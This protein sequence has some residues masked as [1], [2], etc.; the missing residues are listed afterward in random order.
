MVLFVCTQYSHVL[1]TAMLFG[2]DFGS[3]LGGG[4]VST[5]LAMIL[6]RFRRLVLVLYLCN[7]GTL[8][9]LPLYGCVSC[10]LTSM[11]GMTWGSV[12]DGFL[13]TRPGVIVIFDFL[14]TL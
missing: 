11:S 13:F 1:C 10:G 8:Y 6:R 4:I 3:C 5:W 7:S 12:Y 9:M 14:I 2:D